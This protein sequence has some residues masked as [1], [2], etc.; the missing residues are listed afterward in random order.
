MSQIHIMESS[1]QTSSPTADSSTVQ[2]CS[3]S[4]RTK[5]AM[6]GTSSRITRHLRTGLA[7]SLDMP[8]SVRPFFRLTSNGFHLFPS[9][10]TFSSPKKVQKARISFSSVILVPGVCSLSVPFTQPTSTGNGSESS[11]PAARHRW[12]DLHRP[13]PLVLSLALLRPS[14][15]G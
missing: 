4:V 5:V 8:P 14:P 7:C 13:L 10:R 1:T 15:G 6:P 2:P 11:R 12:P 3:N 9:P